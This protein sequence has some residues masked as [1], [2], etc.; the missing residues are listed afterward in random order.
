[1]VGG[2]HTKLNNLDNCQDSTISNILE[3]NFILFYD[4]GLLDR[5]G[6]FNIKIPQSGIW[7][8]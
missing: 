2:P 5:G 8:R 7:W 6:F 4:W 1:M 3:E